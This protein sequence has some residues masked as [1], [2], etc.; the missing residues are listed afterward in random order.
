[1]AT[2]CEA[3]PSIPLHVVEDHNHALEHI[4]RAIGRKK[5]SFSEICLVH[6][7]AH[8]DLLCPENMPS[9]MVYSKEELFDCLSISDWILPA[10]YAGHLGSVIWLKPPWCSQ[11]PDGRYELTVG[12]HKEDGLLK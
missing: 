10:V 11:I 9:E 1:M 2:R 3:E 12:R 7:D 4:Y 6:F 5:L 8:P